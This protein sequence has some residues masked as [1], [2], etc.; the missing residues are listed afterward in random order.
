[1][2]YFLSKLKNLM[3]FII[4]HSLTTKKEEGR[5]QRKED[6]NNNKRKLICT[7]QGNKINQVNSIPFIILKNISCTLVRIGSLYCFSCFMFV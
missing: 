1:M 2:M 6:N 7:T 3:Y 5:K 4:I